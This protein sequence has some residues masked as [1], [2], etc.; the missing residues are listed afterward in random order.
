MPEHSDS[1]AIA[2]LWPYSLTSQPY[3]SQGMESPSAPNVVRSS[4]A[5]ASPVDDYLEG[6]KAVD[7]MVIC[8]SR[9]HWQTNKQRL[10]CTATQ[11]LI[12]GAGGIPHSLT[13]Q[14]CVTTCGCTNFS[15]MDGWMGGERSLRFLVS[16]NIKGAGCQQSHNS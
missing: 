9:M 7:W 13:Y 14:Q 6:R 2:P 8:T 5:L 10:A 4:Q 3:T 16:F 11:R 12:Q 1:V 15:C